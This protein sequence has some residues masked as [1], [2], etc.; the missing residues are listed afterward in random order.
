MDRNRQSINI[1]NQTANVKHE[2]S[3]LI[4]DSMLV[5]EDNL[6]YTKNSKNFE[7]V[8]KSKNESHSKKKGIPLY[9]IK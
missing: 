5:D 1:K 3:Q 6:E 2:K 9:E 4:N 7:S 8:E